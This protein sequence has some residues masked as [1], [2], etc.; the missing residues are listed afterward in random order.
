MH[1]ENFFKKDVEKFASLLHTY[2]IFPVLHTY[3]IFS[4]ETTKELN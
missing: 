3:I 4:I 1:K 2:I